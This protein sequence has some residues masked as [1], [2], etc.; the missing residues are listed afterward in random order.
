MP[1]T[2]SAKQAQRTSERRHQENLKIKAIY[3]NAIKGVKKA[4]VSGAEDVSQLLSVAQS[5]LDTAA[6][7]K[8]IHRNKAARLKSRLAKRISATPAEVAAS[9]KKAST[10]R[11]T[12]AATKK[13]TTAKKVAAAK[14]A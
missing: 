8:T 14:A 4:I 6:K 11:K 10:P 7:S 13:A 3:K 2:K 12:A 1:V 9:T 5:A